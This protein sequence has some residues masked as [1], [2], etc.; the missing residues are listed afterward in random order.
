MEQDNWTNPSYLPPDQQWANARFPLIEASYHSRLDEFTLRIA[1]SFG[2]AGK[3]DGTHDGVG[4][5]Q[6]VAFLTDNFSE[7]ATTL[8]FDAIVVCSEQG[9]LSEAELAGLKIN[10]M[11]IE[12]GRA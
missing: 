6:V 3:Y 4:F 8:I 7:D 5:Q 2:Y 1:R 10:I 11:E 9:P 12:H